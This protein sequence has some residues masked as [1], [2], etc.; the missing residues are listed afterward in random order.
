MS[1]QRQ[2]PS[3]IIRQSQRHLGPA[4]SRACPAVGGGAGVNHREPMCTSEPLDLFERHLV[5]GSLRFSWSMPERD[6]QQASRLQKRDQ[7][8][9]GTW[10][11]S[12]GNML[13]NGTQQDDICCKT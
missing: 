11:V 12:R 3:A 10:P 8:A 1:Q 9:K 7:L 5:H 13:P 4:N 2:G 6:G